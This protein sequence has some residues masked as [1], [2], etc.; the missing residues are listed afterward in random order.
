M[1]DP[2]N[3]TDYNLTDAE[4]EERLLFWVC[5]A[6]K[7]GTT[8]A[9]CLNNML[10]DHAVFYQKNSPLKWALNAHVLYDLPQVLKHYGIGCYTGKAKTFFELAVAVHKG[11]NLRT[12]SSDDLEKIYGIG[13]KTSRCFIIHSR[14]NA[15]YAGLDT[16]ILKY[17]KSQGISN[18]PKS[19][20]GSKKEYLRLEQEFLKLADEA[21]KSPADFDLEIWNKYSV[22]IKGV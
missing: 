7:N 14:P 9:R 3:V 12:C 20:P 13:M 22:K 4:L 2:E 21:E 15:R 1:V 11:L 16:H 10:T 19:T 18:V 8:A 17:L 6:G 5:A